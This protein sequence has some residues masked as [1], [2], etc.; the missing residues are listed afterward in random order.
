M[1]RTSTLLLAFAL[2][3]LGGASY[4]L[5]ETVT[6]HYPAFV[7]VDPASSNFRVFVFK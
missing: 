4:G 1:T 6:H 2:I 3:A 7:S 5:K